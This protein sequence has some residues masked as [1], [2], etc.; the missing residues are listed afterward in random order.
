MPE[1]TLEDRI[2]YK[3][4]YAYIRWTPE[5][6]A[7]VR[8]ALRYLHAYLAGLQFPRCFQHDFFWLKRSL[9]YANERHPHY[10]KVMHILNFL[11]PDPA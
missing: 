5:P 2:Y 4:A 10:Q 3:Y 9:W 7:R 1:E 11:V 6:P 8:N